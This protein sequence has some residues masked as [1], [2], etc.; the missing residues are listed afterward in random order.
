MFEEIKST[1]Y[2]VAIGDA[3][4]LAHDTKSRQ[5]MK[6]NPVYTIMDGFH[7]AGTYSDDTALTLALLDGL[8][9]FEINEEDLME[10][11]FQAA[12]M[13]KYAAI[14]NAGFGFGRTTIEALSNYKNEIKPWGRSSF[15]SNGN[16]ALMRHSP[17]PLYLYYSGISDDIEK[18]LSFSK[19]IT[20][21]THAHPIS[22]IASGIYTLFMIELLKDSSPDVA[23]NRAYDLAKNYYNRD[24]ITREY[25]TYFKRLNDLDFHYIDETKIKSTGY[26]I[27]SLEASLW[28]FIPTISFKEAIIRACNLGGDTDTICAITGSMAALY[29]GMENI[30]KDFIIRIKNSQLI[31]EMIQKFYDNLCSNF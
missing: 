15:H 6:E 16:G 10:N 26:V 24:S 31:D 21:L 20:A 8:S 18:V 28:S 5:M 7:E 2:G 27:D 23:L 1:I 13:N 17:V 9:K 14:E 29:Y 12:F 4:G 22:I 19:T 3:F 11:F 30:P 25:F